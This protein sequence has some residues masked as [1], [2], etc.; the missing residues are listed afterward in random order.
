MENDV[1][2]DNPERNQSATPKKKKRLSK[3]LQKWLILALVP[4][5]AEK[6]MKWFDR[7]ARANDEKLL[8]LIDYEEVIERIKSHCNPSIIALWHNRLVFGPTAI[9]YIKGNGTALMVSRSFDGDIISATMARF[10]N[11]I[12]V[13]GGSSK[14]ADQDKGGKE[15]LAAMIEYGKKGYDLVITPD[16]PQGPVYKVKPGVVELAKATGYPIFPSGCNC[17]KY[18]QAKSWD[19]TRVPLPYSYFVYKVG[20]PI[21]VPPDADEEMLEQKRLEVERSLTELAEFVDHYFD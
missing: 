3:R 10:N 12:P 8:D 11:I 4:I 16:G 5:L 18:L 20:P 9:N 6:W 2:T 19:R 7:T 13:R 15:A 1:N 14:R 21:T 17:T